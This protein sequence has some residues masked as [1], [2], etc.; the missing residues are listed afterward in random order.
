LSR[1]SIPFAKLLKLSRPRFWI[2]VL[3]PYLVGL[4]A[5][6]AALNDFNQWPVIL[7]GLFFTFPANLLIYGVNDIFDYETDK[8]NIKKTDYESLVTPAERPALWKIIALATL[9]FLI[10]LPVVAPAALAALAAFLFFSIYY[11][12]PPL[13]AK[14]KPMLDSAFN[15]LYIFPGVFAYYLSGGRDLSVQLVIAAWC[16]AMAM[17]AYSAVPDI[18]ADRDSNLKTVATL[19]GFRG[20][21]LLCLLLYA[22]SAILSFDALG[23]LSVILGTAYVALMLYSMTRRSEAELLRVYKI[24]PPINT[25]SGGALFF[26]VF[27]SKFFQSL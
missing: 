4:A 17:H 5:G 19:F 10:V 9:P 8:N 26:A 2:Y 11:S 15:V 25:I 27:L 3:G 22:A 7:F 14:A 23:V 12:A 6:A 1:S 16:W 20:T 13:R 24:F 18:S 21:L